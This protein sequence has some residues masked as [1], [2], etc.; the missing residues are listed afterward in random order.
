MIGSLDDYNIKAFPSKPRM[1]FREELFCRGEFG[2][3][4]G[5]EGSFDKES[6]CTF[7]LRWSISSN[8]LDTVQIF[9]RGRSFLENYL[10]QRTTW[11]QI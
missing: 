9:T 2:C 6:R 11:N 10:F 8:Q 5:V 1:I 4:E 3:L 7:F